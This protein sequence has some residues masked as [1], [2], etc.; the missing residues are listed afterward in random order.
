MHSECFFSADHNPPLYHNSRP[1]KR[2]AKDFDLPVLLVVN[3]ERFLSVFCV[4]VFCFEIVFS[5]RRIQSLCKFN[6]CT[7]TDPQ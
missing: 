2:V 4:F 7:H 6:D 1:S 3:T 5:L